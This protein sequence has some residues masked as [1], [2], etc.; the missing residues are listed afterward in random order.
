MSTCADFVF[1]YKAD[2]KNLIKPK[3]DYLSFTKPSD[4]K[5]SSDIIEIIISLCFELVLTG[6]H[7]CQK[8]LSIQRMFVR[9]ANF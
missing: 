1:E 6:E 7:N 3:N 2:F 8:S 9:N 5:K 4:S